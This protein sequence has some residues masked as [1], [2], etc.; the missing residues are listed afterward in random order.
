[1]RRTSKNGTVKVGVL[2]L[3]FSQSLFHVAVT[4]NELIREKHL[5]DKEGTVII[6]YKRDETIAV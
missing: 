5:R 1:M 4:P 3:I 6:D 2:T